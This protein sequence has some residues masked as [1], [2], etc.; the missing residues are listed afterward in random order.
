MGAAGSPGLG[1]GKGPP[2]PSRPLLHRGWIMANPQAENG[3][4]DIA[5][6]I[7]EALARQ[8]ISP[9]EWRCFMTIIRKTWGWHKR[10]DW[11]SLSQFV[12]A[13]GMTRPHICRALSKLEKRNLVARSGN[14]VA[15]T[16]NAKG[17]LYRIQKDFE[18]WKALPKQAIVAQTGNESLP[19]QAHTKEKIQKKTTLRDSPNPAVKGFIDFWF[20]AFREKFKSP[21]KVNDGK[22]GQLV[23]DLLK[24]YP[25]D[26]LKALAGVFFA[27]EDP[28]ILKSGYSIGFFHNQISKVIVEESRRKASW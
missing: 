24:T 27:S 18:K 28:F 26:R 21:Y 22:D 20:Q 9:D 7:L 13:T 8:I 6:E 4:T 11:I 19:K 1:H 10:E 2:N 12:L 5:N 17:T 15:Q 3:H 16:G 23:K 14:D 25:L